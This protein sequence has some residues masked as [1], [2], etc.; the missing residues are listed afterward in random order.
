MRLY[1]NCESAELGTA[2]ASRLALSL[3]R[4]SP[5]Q[6]SVPKPYWKVPGL[7]EFTYWLSPASAASFREVVSYSSGAWEHSSAGGELSSVWNR[8]TDHVFLIPEVTWADL[9]LYEVA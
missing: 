2:M 6:A 3:S 4:F 5:V 8:T 1:A 9:Q 7:F